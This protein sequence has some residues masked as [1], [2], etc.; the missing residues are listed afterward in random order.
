MIQIDIKANRPEL[1]DSNVETDDFAQN[2]DVQYA[3]EE[4]CEGKHILI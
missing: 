4:L 1:I 3:I 2:S